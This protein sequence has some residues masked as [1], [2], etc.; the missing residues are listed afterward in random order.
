VYLD[1]SMVMDESVLRMVFD[2]IDSSRVLYATDF[3]V[4]A[5]A[6]RRVR[7][8]DHWVD[9]V[10]SDAPKSGFR[11][12]AEGIPGAPMAHEIAFAVLAAGRAAGLPAE[13][14]RGVFFE[15]GMKVLMS[16]NGGTALARVEAGWQ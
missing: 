10:V 15:N 8:M 3:P 7:V 11:V 16:V 1:T 14:L 13:E 2:G 6:G 4:A 9:V 12:R 5:M